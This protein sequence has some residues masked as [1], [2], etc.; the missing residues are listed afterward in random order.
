MWSELLSRS[1]YEPIRRDRITA[2]IRHKAPRRVVVGDC[3]TVLFESR[4]SVL[5]QIQEVLYAEGC[6]GADRVSRTIEEYRQLLPAPGKLTATV[7]V[8]GGPADVASE[9]SRAIS[10]RPG[11]LRLQLGSA[12]IDSVCLDDPCH[13]ESPV[14]YVRFD[15]PK[16]AATALSSKTVDA[17]LSLALGHL[18]ST[19]LLHSEQRNALAEN[20]FREPSL[21]T[22]NSTETVQA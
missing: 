12:E 2:M 18:R 9:T 19:V 8:D 1:E 7:F 21:E 16:P 22:A 13:L 11:A 5:H 15:L 3:V 17:S 20:L 4:R 14:L 10:S 6:L